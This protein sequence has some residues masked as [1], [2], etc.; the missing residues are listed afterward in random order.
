MAASNQVWL[1]DDDTTLTELLSEY[2]EQNN[3]SVRCFDNGEPLLAAL[4]KDESPDIMVLD[5]MMPGLTGLQLLPAIRN[6]VDTP[7]IMLTGRGDEIDRIL[8]L[9]LGADDYM[10][11]P[12]NP[13]ELLARI[14]AIVRRYQAAPTQSQ[15]GQQIDHQGVNLDMGMLTCSYQDQTV[16]LTGIEFSVLAE[17]VN[18]AGNLVSKADLT[19]RVLHRKLTAYDR[20]IDVHVSRVRQKLKAAGLE[21]DVIKT[22]RGKGYQFIK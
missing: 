13:R 17:L 10:A 19:E 2:L 4:N 22:V 21:N 14:Q 5:I 3:F 16:D 9:E 11:K 1:I 18:N 12:C 20:S 6:H 15:G 8:G 7:V